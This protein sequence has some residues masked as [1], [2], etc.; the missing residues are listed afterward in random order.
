MIEAEIY[1]MM[2]RP[3]IVMN[4][5]DRPLKNN[6]HLGEQLA[7]GRIVVQLQ[8]SSHLLLIDD[9]QGNLVTN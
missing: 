1:G 9:R 3:R 2:L 8:L 4:S 6:G 7:E 5:G